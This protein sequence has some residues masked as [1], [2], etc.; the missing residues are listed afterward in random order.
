MKIEI[1]LTNSKYCEGC[2]LH[3]TKEIGFGKKCLAEYYSDDM[4]C[5][6]MFNCEVIDI[7]TKEVITQTT[8]SR[9]V[10]PEKCI[11]ENGE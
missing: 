9:T 3:V 7:P 6:K 8:I 1:K 10:R 4:K 2:L 11:K 5:S